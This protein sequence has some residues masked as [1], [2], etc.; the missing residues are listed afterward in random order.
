[1]KRIINVGLDVHKNSIT[2]A[3]MT[4]EGE[5]LLEKK[6]K[7]HW[8]H[9]EKVLKNLIVHYPHTTLRCCYEAGPTGF[10]LARRINKEGNMSCIVAAPG[11][12]PRRV[13]RI[14]TDRRDA[15]TL[16][17]HLIM[18]EIS[19]V[20]I[21]T[22]EDEET[23]ELL[24]YRKVQRKSL[25]R[26]KQQLGALLLRHD[27]K[28]EGKTAWSKQ[29]KAWI[30]KIQ[31]SSHTYSQLR[32]RY[33]AQ[34]KQLEQE[35][36]HIEKEIKLISENERYKESTD[37]LTLLRG[38][39]RLTAVSFCAEVGD[40]KRFPNAKGFMGYLGLVPSEHSSGMKIVKGAIT[41]QGNKELRR[42]LIESAWQYFLPH[43]RRKMPADENKK[44]YYMYAEKANDRLQR[45]KY[46]LSVINRKNNKVTATAIAREMAGFIWGM[47]TDNIN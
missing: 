45:K 27:Y 46:R 20:N 28:Y 10:G 21:P 44:S 29:H 35:L 8:P 6:I 33:L 5:I 37:R 22:E 40:F 39:G 14:K 13:N 3:V 4:G 15:L 24:R 23:R 25:K 11:K 47:M 7:N 19:K 1:M 17:R 26:Y 2:I 38:I 31:F 34:I 42:L 18:G 16:T 9:M 30:R 43:Q 41:K 12:I 36:D 32:D